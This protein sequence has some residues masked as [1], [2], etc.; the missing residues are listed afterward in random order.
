M[1][2]S[3]PASGSVPH[4]SF[5]SRI[6]DSYAYTAKTARLA[7]DASPRNLVFLA[8]LTLIAATLPILIAWVGK[9]LVDAVVLA[10]AATS[11]DARQHAITVTI[12]WVVVECVL[13]VVTG[14]VERGLMAVRQLLGARLAIHIN[15]LIVE[16]ALTF[17]LRHFEDSKFYDRLTQAR[18][19]ASSRPLALLQDN[20]QFVRNG[21]TFLGYALLLLRFSPWAVVGLFL[22]ALPA[23]IAE[24]RFSG[25]GF[26]IRNARSPDTRRLNYL[27]HIL[28]DDHHAKEVKLFGLQAVL[29]ERYKKLAESFYREDRQ[30]AVSQ[31]GWGSIMSV[32]S[33]VA[34]YGCY[35][36]AALGAATGRLS[37][38]D[39]TLYALA[40][41]QGRTALQAI[42]SRIG[43]MYEHN[44]YMSNL[45]GYLAIPTEREFK[46]IP[47]ALAPLSERGI[48]FEDVGFRYQGSD[49]WALRHI[50]VF[51]PSGQSLALVGE[52]GAGKTTF[53]KLLTGLY[54]PSEGRVL[55]DGRDLRD[56]DEGTLRQRM[57]VI[58]QDF[59]RYH[60][61]LRE[62]VGFGS[63]EH[64]ADNR[65]INRAVDR[66]GARDIV[67]DLSAG[68]ETQLGRRFQNGVELSGGQWQR[69]ALARAFMREEADI[70]VLDEPTAALDAN[71]E[72]AIFT[73]FRSLAHG[74][75]AI[76]ISHRFP[77]V[78]NASRILVLEH[79]RIKE[80]GS[81]TELI[82]AGGRYAQLFALQAEGY[83]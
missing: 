72:H 83:R 46:K 36:A 79:G 2:S 42:L 80:E 8:L 49:E 33:N 39:M 24:I 41:R 29:L 71:A 77:T 4:L 74:R 40:F 14:V 47:S 65:R 26:K 19:E 58:F 5:A 57:G 16:K 60:F 38:G 70:L 17:Q 34:F 9:L 54:E 53:I 31:A 30:L 6:R 44:L 76:F 55:V 82:A 28:T 78:R 23:F 73:R 11:D 66:G 18:R 63:V 10:Q 25:T 20:M 27:E 48:R 56:W 81:H 61:L 37:L 51:I 32:L 43:T 64:I 59:N 13:V 75:T 52:N 1:I 69:V 67:A 21:L 22:A 12:R 62:N 68:I 7:W 15:T 45:F 35:L 3:V 50:S